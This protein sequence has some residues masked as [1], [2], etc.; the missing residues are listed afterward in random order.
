MD[1]LDFSK[2]CERHGKCDLDVRIEVT[3]IGFGGTPTVDIKSV[4]AGFDWDKGKLLLTPEN[5]L[6]V[7]P[8]K[9]KIKVFFIHNCKV[10]EG[11][12][13]GF[14]GTSDEVIIG[15]KRQNI[16]IWISYSKC[17]KTSCEAEIILAESL[18]E[19]A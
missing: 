5:P 8:C 7:L 19:K 13:E 3:G 18:P 10:E 16:N 11:L 14:T 2:R 15:C 12:V 17:Y 4:H 1:L 9:P 6:L